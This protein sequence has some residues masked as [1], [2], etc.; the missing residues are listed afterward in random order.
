[1]AQEKKSQKKVDYKELSNKRCTEC[2]KPLKQNIVSRNPHARLRY[3]CFKISNGKK[4][5]F[6]HKVSVNGEKT[7]LKRIDYLALQKQNK[8]TYQRR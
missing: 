6:P 2:G 1:M 7:P 4:E 5:S 8:R 3:V